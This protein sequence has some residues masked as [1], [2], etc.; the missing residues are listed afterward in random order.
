MGS[1]V[2]GLMDMAYSA[3]STYMTMLKEVHFA[4]GLLEARRATRIYMHHK[5]RF[6]LIGTS[7]QFQKIDA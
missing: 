6:H 5:V 4:V 3:K 2:R 7:A 1:G